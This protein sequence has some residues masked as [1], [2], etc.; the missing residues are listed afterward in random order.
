MFSNR[1]ASVLALFAL[2]T[3]RSSLLTAQDSA[4]GAIRGTVSDASGGRI[5]QA[6][7]VAVNA[8]TSRRYTTNSDAEG[9]FALD[10]L[11]PGDYSARVEAPGMSPQVTS[12][13]RRSLPFKR[14][15]RGRLNP[16]G[17]MSA[18]NSL[19]EDSATAASSF[20]LYF[21]RSHENYPYLPPRIPERRERRSHAEL[22]SRSP[23][24]RRRARG[25]W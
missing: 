15:C 4:T 20:P 14:F 11:P 16:R 7:I 9:R 25:I 21:R 6:L 13:G 22:G 8:A 19:D 5:T 23:T 18:Q 12:S 24:I 10:L 2:L 3:L 1:A 17:H